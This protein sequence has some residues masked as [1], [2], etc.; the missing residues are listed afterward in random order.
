ML[1]E[2]WPARAQFCQGRA[3]GGRE[4]RHIRELNASCNSWFKSQNLLTAPPPSVP[5]AK[6]QPL[7]AWPPPSD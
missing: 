5:T 2:S 7:E 3:F 4:F 1:L 6:G